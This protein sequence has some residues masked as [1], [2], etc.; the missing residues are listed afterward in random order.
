MEVITSNPLWCTTEDGYPAA[1]LP[2]RHYKALLI[3]S[4]EAIELVNPSQIMSEYETGGWYANNM[5]DRATEYMNN[6]LDML[7]PPETECIPGVCTLGQNAFLLFG[8]IQRT[9]RLSKYKRFLRSLPIGGYTTLLVDG[10]SELIDHTGERAKLSNI[11]TDTKKIELVI[12]FDGSISMSP[13]VESL[14]PTA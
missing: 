2:R 13:V 14:E 8:H 7:P 12:L 11:I 1:L 5:I 9:P 4:L 10:E 3:E 6:Q